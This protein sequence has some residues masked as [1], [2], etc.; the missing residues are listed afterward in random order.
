[1]L[2]I[3]TNEGVVPVTSSRLSNPIRELPDTNILLFNPVV[4]VVNEKELLMVSYDTVTPLTV[5][6]EGSSI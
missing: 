1:M 3:L 2:A 5:L 4:P 6:P